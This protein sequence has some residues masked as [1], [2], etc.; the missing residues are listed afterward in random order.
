MENRELY[1]HVLEL[2]RAWQVGR[3]QLDVRQERWIFGPSMKKDKVGRIPSV[4]LIFRPMIMHP[5]RRQIG[6]PY[7]IGNSFYL[8]Y[9]PKTGQGNKVQNGLP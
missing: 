9:S 5:N 4:E 8:K 3:A 7:I 2:E 6:I 1:R